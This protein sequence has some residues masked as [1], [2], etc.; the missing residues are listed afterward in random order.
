MSYPTIML[1]G[2]YFTI[3]PIAQA[4][5][6][7]GALVYAFGSRDRYG[8]G[9]ALYVGQTSDANGYFGRSHPKWARACMLGMNE[10]A[11]HWASD[12]DVRFKLETDL[13]R[14]FRPPLNEQAYVRHDAMAAGIPDFR[15]NAMVGSK[16]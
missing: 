1:Q 15:F 4:A 16:V 5:Y 14:E 10:V 9:R 3:F 6:V 7:E 2:A 11:V 8:N 12:K 13:R